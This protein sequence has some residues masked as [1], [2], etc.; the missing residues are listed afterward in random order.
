MKKLK[1]FLMTALICTMACC[2]FLFTGCSKTVTYHFESLKY[3]SDDTSI[4]INIGDKFEGT[5]LTKDTFL[6]LLNDNNTF[7]LRISY[8]VEYDDEE[9]SETEVVIGTWMKGYEKEIYL[10]T[11]D[12]SFIAKKDGKK[13]I[14]EYDVGELTLKK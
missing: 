1:T 10:T 8:I 4:T 6:L 2:C 3:E 11:E 13:I 12:E 9:Y 7:V 14:F 5:E